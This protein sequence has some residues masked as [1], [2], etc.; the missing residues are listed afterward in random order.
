MPKQV[1]KRL[2]F[3]DGEF[4]GAI[5][6]SGRRNRWISFD[7]EGAFVVGRASYYLDVLDAFKARYPAAADFTV[8]K[9]RSTAALRAHFERAAVEDGR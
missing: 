8:V 4:I 5:Y 9:V 3:A 1:D 6:A 7:T 2:V